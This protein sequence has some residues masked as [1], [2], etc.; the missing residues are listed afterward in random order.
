PI[1]RKLHHQSH[2][3]QS[4][5]LPSVLLTLKTRSSS[6]HHLLTPSFGPF[7]FH[8][9]HNR[10]HRRK[11]KQVVATDLIPSILSGPVGLLR[12]SFGGERAG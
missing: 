9:R 1:A 8:H 10:H 5:Y 6:H 4:Q 2:S 12:R 3:S 7:T 11:R